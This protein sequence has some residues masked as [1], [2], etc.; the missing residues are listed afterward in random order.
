VSSEEIEIHTRERGKRETLNSTK[1]YCSGCPPST[2]KGA[3]I[4]VHVCP[5]CTSRITAVLARIKIGINGMHANAVQNG[6]KMFKCQGCEKK[7]VRNNETTLKLDIRVPP[8]CG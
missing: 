4:Q 8:P 2:S 1:M 5:Y 7:K 6:A 3:Y